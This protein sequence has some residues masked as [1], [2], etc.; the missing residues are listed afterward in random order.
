M[1]QKIPGTYK[2]V[3]YGYDYK[4]D[5]RFK[6]ISEF[7][8][9]M[10]HYADTGFMN[11]IVRFAE[12]PEAL[13]DVVSYSGTYKV[14]GAEIVHQVTTSVRPDYE[15]QTL[16]RAFRFEGDELVTEFENTDEFIKYAR[17][18]RL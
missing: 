18:K 5:K 8:T 7:Y 13:E 16:A 10:I 1:S 12:K 2:L 15:G 17:W 9:G 11:V 4:K 14:E 6:P 3:K